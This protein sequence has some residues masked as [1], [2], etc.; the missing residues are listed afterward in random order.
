MEITSKNN[1]LYNT[2]K[3]NS[4]TGEYL[5]T[6]PPGVNYLLTYSYKN[7]P[8]Q[9]LNVDAVD[10]NT[11]TEKIFDA[12]FEVPVVSTPTDVL[13]S[14]EVKKS[15]ATETKAKPEP[16][17]AAVSAVKTE[18]KAEEP[19][20]VAAKTKETAPDKQAE[21]MPVV[22]AKPEPVA[23]VEKNNNTANTNAKTSTEK[24]E[25]VATA[26]SV[27]IKNPFEARPSGTTSA[28]WDFTTNPVT[29][30]PLTLPAKTAS[31][32]TFVAV[33][34]PQ[35]KSMRFAEKY[36]KVAAD[37][38]EFRVQ[39]AAVKNDKNVALPNQK[40]LGKVEKLNLGMVLSASPLAAHLKP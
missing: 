30:T 8:E 31:K 10:L 20:A 14:A 6:L 27:A 29:S 12:S 38:M 32:T 1:R 17:V 19:V 33:N 28:T 2:F 37:D 25:A 26:A 22:D 11:Y 36:G 34:G 39:V 18:T 4:I 40:I 15:D 3:S 24:T 21:T 9:R 13:A 5:I 7:S 35:A 16:T 23:V